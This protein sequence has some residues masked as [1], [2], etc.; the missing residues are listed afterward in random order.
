MCGRFTLTVD[1]L[2]IAQYFDID[3][4][5]EENFKKSYNIAPSQQVLAVV[6]HKGKNRAGYI[7]W[8][9]IP[10]WAKEPSFQLINARG[11]SLQ[12]KP[13]FKH[14]NRRRCLILAD[15]FFEWK[16]EKETKKPVRFLLKSEEPFAFAGLWDKY[17]KNGEVLVTCTIVTTAANEL[18]A[19]IHN[20]MPAILNKGIG[21]NWL[22]PAIT[23]WSDILPLIQAYPACEMKAYEVSPIVNS[24]KNNSEQCIKA[25]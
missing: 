11:E 16:K 19:P 15:S 6:N 4:F 24:P 2:E 14:L 20:R 13:S 17:E 3:E 23:N 8:G 12:E 22:N 9:L 18:V 5:D 21:E 7:K 1:A 25:I 10:F